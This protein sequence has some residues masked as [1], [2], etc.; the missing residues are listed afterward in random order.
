[1]SVKKWYK[2]S[3]LTNLIW[4]FGAIISAPSSH[5]PTGI[6]WLAPSAI[7]TLVISST[8]TVLVVIKPTTSMITMWAAIWVLLRALNDNRTIFSR[9]TKPYSLHG[10]GWVV[11]LPTVVGGVQAKRP[12]TTNIPSDPDRISFNIFYNI[13]NSKSSFKKTLALR[14]NKVS[15]M[16]YFPYSS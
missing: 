15:N 2:Y 16:H 12:W 6:V 11:V 10:S 3:V 1:M 4:F 14:C 9:R 8:T 7:F 13:F 5:T